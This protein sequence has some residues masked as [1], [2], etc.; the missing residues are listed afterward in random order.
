MTT[1]SPLVGIIMGSKSDWSTMKLASDTL[2][3]LA[4]RVGD[5]DDPGRSFAFECS[6][7]DFHYATWATAS[8]RPTGAAG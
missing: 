4:D 6:M 7:Y 5:D 8:S 2:T 3:E 1:P